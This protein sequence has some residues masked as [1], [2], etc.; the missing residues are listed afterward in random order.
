[1]MLELSKTTDRQRILVSTGNYQ[2][3][4][5]YCERPSD[6]MNHCKHSRDQNV[7]KMLMRQIGKKGRNVLFDYKE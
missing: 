3:C 1:M 5:A 7:N 2:Y 6:R 4:C